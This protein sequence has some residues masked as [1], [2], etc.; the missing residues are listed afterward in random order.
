MPK[1]RLSEPL[2]DPDEA[3]WIRDAEDD[4]RAG[5]RTGTDHLAE[6]TRPGIRR[7]RGNPLDEA[8]ALRDHD[9]MNIVE[10]AVRH[11]DCVL[12]YQPVVE[13]RPP[14]R[15]VFHEGLIRVLDPTGRPIPAREFM[16]IV[17][18]SE[19]GR[20]L[21]CASLSLGLKALERHPSLRLSVNMSARTAGYRRWM[22]ILDRALRRDSGIGPRLTLEISEPSIAAVPDLIRDFMERVASRGVAFALDDFGAGPT[23]LRALRDSLFDAVKID[24][25]FIR[26]ITSNQDNEAL[27]R[28]MTGIAHAFGMGLMAVGVESQSDTDFLAAMGVDC[29]QGYGFGAPTLRPPWEN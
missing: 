20:E 29:V 14:H 13:A 4:A 18:T 11:R 17:E 15:V 5:L 22:Q 24:A 6:R 2:P 21:D 28:A 1:T 25:R 23:L 8:V 9:L 26:G 3:A 19:I 7:D 12:A 27:V 16:P 10:Q